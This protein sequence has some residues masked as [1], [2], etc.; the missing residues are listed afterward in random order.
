MAYIE[1]QYISIC[2][3]NKKVL[4]HNE[5]NRHFVP[6]T[7][8]PKGKTEQLYL[9]VIFKVDYHGAAINGKFTA[10][11]MDVYDFKFIGENEEAVTQTFHLDD[12]VFIF[13]PIKLKNNY[14][15]DQCRLCHLVVTAQDTSVQ[16][17][18]GSH[19]HVF[20]KAV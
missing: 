1:I 17:Q 14:D 12:E 18:E 3:S 5:Y 11:F 8:H 6:F 9:K 16:G 10:F 2:D 19:G 4:P 7:P 13:L 15:I 20:F